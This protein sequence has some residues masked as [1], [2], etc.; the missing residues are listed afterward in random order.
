M[1]VRFHEDWEEI[2]FSKGLD[3]ESHVIQREPEE[4]LVELKKKEAN[5]IKGY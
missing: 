1:Q 4:I 5:E 2:M 3:Q